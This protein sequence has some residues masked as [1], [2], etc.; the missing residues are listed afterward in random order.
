ML[1]NWKS[2]SKGESLVRADPPKKQDPKP[3]SSTKADASK[4][5]AANRKRQQSSSVPAT[6]V[7]PKKKAKA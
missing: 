5:P 7:K 4:P 1:Y 2:I 3:A 6:S